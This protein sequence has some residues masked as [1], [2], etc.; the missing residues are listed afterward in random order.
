MTA[1]WLLGWGMA[2]VV[3]CSPVVALLYWLGSPELV[4]VAALAAGT[5]SPLAGWVIGA[6]RE[7][8]K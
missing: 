4:T 5:L 3:I 2:G 6:H 7:G 8:R 1:W